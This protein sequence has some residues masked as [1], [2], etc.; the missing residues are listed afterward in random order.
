MTLDAPYRGPGPGRPEDLPLPPASMPL[1]RDGRWRKRWR[2]V[3]VYEEE[4][5]LCAGVARVGPSRQAWWAIWDREGRVLHERT[6]MLLGRAR[7]H[8]EPGLVHVE[9]G[10]GAI[11]LRLAD[12]RFD[13]E[14]VTPDERSYTWTRKGLALAT[15]TVRAGGRGWALEGRRAFIDESAGYHPRHTAWEWSAG[16]GEARDGRP[17][18]WNLVRGVHDS[19]RDSERTVWVD[20]RP[21]EVGP[22]EFAADLS[23]VSF[24]EGGRLGFAEEAVR[25]RDD[26]LLVFRSRYEQPFGAFS[27]ELPGAGRLARGFGVMERH[28]VHW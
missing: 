17:V 20:G 19:P 11:H 26:N 1:R 27:G 13:V 24:A 7:V 25:R 21:V 28:D 5:M 9:D 4:L 3:G 22:V 14:V 6:R 18:A 2:Y 16:L 12:E 15:G 10:D 23:S 8:V